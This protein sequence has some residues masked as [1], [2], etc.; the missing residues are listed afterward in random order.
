MVAKINRGNNIYGAVAYNQNKVN[1]GT[2]RIIYGN[3]MINDLS[4]DAS[5]VMQKTLLSFEDYLLANK[6]TEKPIL[7]I[8]LNPTITDSLSEEQFSELAKDYMERMGYGD[9]PYNVYLHNDIDRPHIHIVT[10]CVDENGNKINDSYEWRR[11]MKACREL[12]TKY[13]LKQ[14]TD[15]RK[16]LSEIFLKKADY[17]AGD[18][19]HQVSNILKSVFNS[20]RFQTFGE[21]SAMLSCFNIELKQ[22]KGEHDG[23]PFVGIV[24]SVT[25]DNGNA[26]S[27]PIK[28]SLIGKKFGNEGISKR[29]NYNVKE[30]KEGKWQPK[31]KNTIAFAMKDSRHDSDLF[32]KMLHGKGIDV[33]MRK[34]KQGRIYGVTFIDHNAREVYN[35]SRLSKEYSANNLNDYF[36]HGKEQEKDNSESQEYKLS[37]NEYD[38]SVS[39]ALGIFG[40][41]QHGVD[42]KEEAFAKKL[43]KKKKKRGRS[44]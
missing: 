22:V 15:T 1:E 16:E 28:S 12:E 7:H 30:Y 43:R 19:K 4:G 9:Q 13:N 35:G 33:L 39:Q 29:I 20:Y 41:E 42:Y 17:K 14:V 37:D 21:Y 10:T 24:Y 40:F 25:D 8:S 44:I 18:L 3:R 5:N 23:V 36:S 11:S 27:N 32:C 2:A 34:N 26:V 6:N 31:I 38:T